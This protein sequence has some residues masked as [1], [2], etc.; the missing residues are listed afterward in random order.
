MTTRLNLADRAAITKQTIDKYR[1]EA[2]NFER[3]VTCLHLFRDH[4]IAMG[5]KPPKI[6]A[7]NSVRG[8]AKAMKAAGHPNLTAIADKVLPLA[9]IAPAQMLVGDIG[10]LPGEPFEAIVIWAG[11]K[12]FGWHDS[13]L[14][15]LSVITDV[16]MDTFI[17]AW[18]V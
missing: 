8:A 10:L 12:M 15:K 16:P 17:A 13:D 11:G 7:F 4:L 5:H 2:L 9:R 1:F 6:P 3:Q 14:S 18:R